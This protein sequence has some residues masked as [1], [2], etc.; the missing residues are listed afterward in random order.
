[1]KNILFFIAMIVLVIGV[2][3]LRG[4]NLAVGGYAS[5]CTPVRAYTQSLI[6]SPNDRNCYL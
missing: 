3:Q 6:A 4:S 5:K 2:I 1:M